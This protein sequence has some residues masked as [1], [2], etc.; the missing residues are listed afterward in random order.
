MGKEISFTEGTGRERITHLGPGTRV[1]EVS[2]VAA[3]ALPPVIRTGQSG[4]AG[5]RDLLVAFSAV[6]RPA[7][8]AGF[9]RL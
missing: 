9:A 5:F 1:P 6:H 8:R 7:L 4:T 3:A 2:A